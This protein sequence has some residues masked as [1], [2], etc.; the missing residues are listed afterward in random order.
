MKR[1]PRYLVVRLPDH[2]PT[3][4]EGVAFEFAMRQLVNLVGD[5]ASSHPDYNGE[6]YDIGLLML[7]NDDGKTTHKLWGQ[8]HSELGLAAEQS[9][10]RERKSTPAGLN[11]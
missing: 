3:P 5:M 6:E 1:R 9:G 11:D 7:H 2:F 10:W 4:V 8:I